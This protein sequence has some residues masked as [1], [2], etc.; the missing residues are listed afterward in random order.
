MTDD[1][2]IER[3]L[4]ELLVQLRGSPRIVRRVLAEAESHLQDA[5]AA[6]MD[7][8]EAISRFGNAPVVAAASNRLSGTPSPS[9]CDSFSWPRVCS[10]RSGSQPSAPAR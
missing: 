2:A 5:V 6:G 8:D 10:R 4:D 1:E 3:Y 9:W 7:A